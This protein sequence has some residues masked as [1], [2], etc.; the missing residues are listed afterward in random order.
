MQLL[1]WCG[2]RPSWPQLLPVS[3]TGARSFW[4]V[5]VA[6]Q[7]E[8]RCSSVKRTVVSAGVDARAFG[9]IWRAAILAAGLLRL[10]VRTVKN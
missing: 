3:G 8:W 7:W 5:K 4:G 1:L 6:Y 9:K 10:W 2:A